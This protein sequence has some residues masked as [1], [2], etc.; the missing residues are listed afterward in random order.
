MAFKKQQVP[1]NN[2][3]MD[4]P[5]GLTLHILLVVLKTISYIYL[6]KKKKKKDTD[7]LGLGTYVNAGTISKEFHNVLI[8]A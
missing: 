1:K 6:K 8:N 3:L 7:E 4:W 2:C 5:R